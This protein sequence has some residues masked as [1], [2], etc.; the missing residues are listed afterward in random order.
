MREREIV[1]VTVFLLTLHGVT[2]HHL[3]SA[4]DGNSQGYDDLAL[5]ILSILLCAQ[6]RIF[7]TD[8]VLSF[9]LSQTS[10]SYGTSKT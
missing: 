10:K 6:M 3:D 7:T 2:L 5:N 4:P 9:R 1:G 8:L